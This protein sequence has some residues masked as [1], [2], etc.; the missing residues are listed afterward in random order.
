MDEMKF[1]MGGAAAVFGTLRAAAELALPFNVVGLVPTCENMP[2]GK[3]VKPA[4]I[5]TSCR[6][7]RSRS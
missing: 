7:K 3:A 6:A 2:G 5:V 1:D 4:D